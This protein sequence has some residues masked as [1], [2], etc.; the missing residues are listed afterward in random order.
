MPT[1]LNANDQIRHGNTYGEGRV[2]R[3]AT[4][5]CGAVCQRW[6]YVFIVYTT[7]GLEYDAAERHRTADVDRLVA[8]RLDD[9]RRVW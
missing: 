3:S 2:F 9:D 8:G 6:L 4:L 5:L 1:S 7:I